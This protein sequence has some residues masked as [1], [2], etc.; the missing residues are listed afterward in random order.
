VCAGAITFVATTV[1]DHAT[2]HGVALADLGSKVQGLAFDKVV[3]AWRPFGFDV[4][5]FFALQLVGVLGLGLT[6][7]IA[8][9]EITGA[10]LAAAT[11]EGRV[12]PLRAKLISWLYPD[13]TPW[14]SAA[15]LGVLTV[16]CLVIASGWLQ[17]FLLGDLHA[18]LAH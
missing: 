7:V 3:A 9:K 15:W 14:R 8:L 18:P 11:L 17:G 2:F 1:I 10:G 12:T 4:I 5:L 6:A 13:V 16:L